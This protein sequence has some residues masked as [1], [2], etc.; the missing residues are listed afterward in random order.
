MY[1]EG[2]VVTVIII[3]VHYVYDYLRVNQNSYSHK[4]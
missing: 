3:V 4:L 1:D 2:R